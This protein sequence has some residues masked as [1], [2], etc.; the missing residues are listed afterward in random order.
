MK[1]VVWCKR[2]SPFLVDV[3]ERM[4]VFEIKKVIARVINV[5]PSFQQ[6]VH[7]GRVLQDDNR[8]TQLELSDM[9]TI[10]LVVKRLRLFCEQRS[11]ERGIGRAQM[12]MS[13]GI[14]AIPG[15]GR[16]I[17]AMKSRSPQ[18]AHA[19]RDENAL[20]ANIA[21]YYNPATRGELLKSVDRTLNMVESRYRGFREIVAHH[22]TVDA[23]VTSLEEGSGL[24]GP[25]T[26]MPEK[27]TK[28]STDP[29]PLEE[30]LDLCCC[31]W[32]G[33]LGKAW[34]NDESF[35]K[36]VE[37]M[38]DIIKKHKPTHDTG[39]GE[40]ETEE[41]SVSAEPEFKQIFHSPWS[42]VHEDDD[43]EEE[44]EGDIEVD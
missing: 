21:A 30:S 10:Y 40:M 41:N 8:V 4:T 12:V 33:E 39:M 29:L 24:S 28:P 13:G 32:H 31:R 22:R 25:E 16:V 11:E 3:T 43:M 23:V 44:E 19:L 42:G 15:L 1:L 2:D 26:V 37:V 9:G 38:T 27:A 20:G 34:C 17:E 36:Y 5:L 35:R 7:R 18:F 6:L 14:S